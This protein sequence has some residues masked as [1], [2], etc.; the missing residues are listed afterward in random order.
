M[1]KSSFFNSVQASDGSYDRE[2]LAE[3]F[4][5]YFSSFIGNGV[6]PNPSSNLQVL[7]NND[8]T[9]SIDVGK[10]YING[11]YYE[12]TTKLVK[13]IA[14]ADGVLNRVDLIVLRLDF[15][16][17]EIK[18]YVKKGTF[19]SSPKAETLQRD[20]D[21]YELG[22]AQVYIGAGATTIT[23]GD[24]TDLR[25]N[26][27]YCGVVHGVVDQVDTTTIFNQFEAWLNENKEKYNKDITEWTEE[28]QNEFTRWTEEK[29]EEFIK[30]YDTNTTAFLNKF[31]T[32]FG[33]NTNDWSTEFTNWFNHIKDQ[34]STDAAGNLQNQIDSVKNTM[35][36]ELS[37]R[38]IIDKTTNNEF[39]WGIENGN[40]FL[41]RIGD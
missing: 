17:R 16:N 6:F 33:T 40:L 8:M 27:D 22:I 34:L 31:N 2:Y 20:S 13:T 26:N 21:M 19:A 5:K 7:S 25:L 30:W 9:I 14:V 28:K 41:E 39:K 36:S 1:E 38:K 10:A 32:W 29:Q 23:Q 37:K 12:N 15:T 35:N 18:T 3:D 4:A 11:Y 24:I